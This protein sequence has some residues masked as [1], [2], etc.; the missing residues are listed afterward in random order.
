MLCAES[1]KVK[2]FR[3]VTDSCGSGHAREEGDSVDGTGFA[4][5]RGRARSHRWSGWLVKLSWI[6]SGF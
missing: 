6:W 2:P 3:K 5:V 1:A 4:G